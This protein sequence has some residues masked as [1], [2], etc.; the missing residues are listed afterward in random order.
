ML[1]V[2]LMVVSWTLY[3][4][5]V[6]DAMA[7]ERAA[8]YK[9]SPKMNVNQTAEQCFQRIQDQIP[10]FLNSPAFMKGIPT[11]DF[12]NQLVPI[13]ITPT[14]YATLSLD[15][16]NNLVQEYV[17]QN[18]PACMKDVGGGYVV[19][20]L[21]VQAN[22]E[23][24]G[25]LTI[26]LQYKTRWE[27]Q[28]VKEGPVVFTFYFNPKHLLDFANHYV[29]IQRSTPAIRLADLEALAEQYGISVELSAF[30]STV[31]VKLQDLQTGSRASQP[32]APHAVYLAMQFPWQQPISGAELLPF[33][34]VP[35]SDLVVFK[36]GSFWVLR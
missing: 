23:D 15:T 7:S 25:P 29:N 9:P 35:S 26:N 4:I 8:L 31:A 27:D 3:L 14:R 2:M 21:R 18:F 33:D 19:E 36:L 11:M 22:S 20:K 24:E 16:Y 1:A 6:V 17:S 5:Y 34:K 12:E 28:V 32:H 30:G 13:L 10:A